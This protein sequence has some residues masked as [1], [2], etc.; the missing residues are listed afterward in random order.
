M[1]DTR[2]EL[3][4]MW[5][6]CETAKGEPCRRCPHKDDAG[7]MQYCAWAMGRLMKAALVG[8]TQ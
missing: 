6:D 2:K 5:A 7:K 8:A 4:A 1:S 3:E